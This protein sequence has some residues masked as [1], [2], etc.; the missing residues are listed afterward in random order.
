M[1]DMLLGFLLGLLFGACFGIYGFDKW[2]RWR[3]KD[4]EEGWRGKV[5]KEEKER[6]DSME[7]ED[8]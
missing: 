7:V 5:L 6:K 3:E 1:S 4:V 8:A 2:L